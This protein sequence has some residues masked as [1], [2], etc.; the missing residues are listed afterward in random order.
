[1]ESALRRRTLAPSALPRMEISDEIS[2][3][4]PISRIARWPDEIG[5]AAVISKQATKETPIASR[6][7]D[8]SSG[9]G[10]SDG[11]GKGDGQGGKELGPGGPFDMSAFKD[12]L[13]GQ[14]DL[15]SAWN[16]LLR[17][18]SHPGL[19][20]LLLAQLSP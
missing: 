14:E 3:E 4:I 5:R 13:S 11:G 2:D 10:K 16:D 9:Q 17:A 18:H 6:L 1:M 20:S 7:E 15:V 12:V 8:M 19:S